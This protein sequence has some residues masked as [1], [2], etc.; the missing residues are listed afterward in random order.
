MNEGTNEPWVFI[1]NFDYKTFK[2]SMAIIS[3]IYIGKFLII[4]KN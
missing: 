2:N 4:V 1:T 3:I